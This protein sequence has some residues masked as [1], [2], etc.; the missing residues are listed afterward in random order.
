MKE[1]CACW[2]ASPASSATSTP[3]ASPPPG[4][5]TSRCTTRASATPA[6]SSTPLPTWP[7]SPPGRSASPWPLAAPSSRCAT[8][9]TSPNPPPPSTNSPAA[10]SSWASPP[11][12]V[13]SSSPPTACNT[14]SAPSA[15]PRRWSTS[16]ACSNPARRALTSPLGHIT[17]AELLPKPAAGPIPLLVT[18]ASGQSPDWIAAHADGWLT[19]PGSSVVPAGPKALGQKIQA[20]RDRIPDGGFRPHATNE[21]IDLVDDPT[22][23]PTLLH[24]GFILQI[25]R[26]ALIDLL[27]QWQTAGVNHVALGIQFSRRPAAEAIQ[28][29]AEEVLPRFPSHEDVPPLDMDW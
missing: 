22:H 28:E 6:S 4:F 23:P 25:G 14:T 7:T 19:Y 13:P 17:D 21:W 29:L 9:S 15:S 18:G 1:T 3:A 2:L 20:W 27:S 24:G 8:P 10:A 11:A 5:A 12:T 26:H 16:A